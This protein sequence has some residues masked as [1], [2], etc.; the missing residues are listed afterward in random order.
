MFKKIL[1][2]MKSSSSSNDDKEKRVI[3]AEGL[4]LGGEVGDNNLLRRRQIRLFIG[5]LIVLVI[6]LGFLI[7]YV[8]E[9]TIVEKPVVALRP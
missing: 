6:I 2:I 9:K 8:Q 7:N 5:L 1:Q 4:G 3:N